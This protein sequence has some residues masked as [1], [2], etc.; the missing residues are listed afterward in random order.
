MPMPPTEHCVLNRRHDS[1]HFSHA[2]DDVCIRIAVYL[3]QLILDEP[4]SRIGR[5][6]C[7]CAEIIHISSGI[8]AEA[9]GIGIGYVDVIVIRTLAVSGLFLQSAYD[10]VVVAA[11]A[12][13]ISETIARKIFIIY[14]RTDNAYLAH[15]QNIGILQEASRSELEALDIG[16]LFRYS[17]HRSGTEGLAAYFYACH[18]G[19]HGADRCNTVAVVHGQLK[20][21]FFADSIGGSPA[22]DRHHKQVCAH[23]LEAFIYHSSKTI[24]EA[25]DDN[26]R[27]YADDYAQHGKS[28]PRLTGGKGLDRKDK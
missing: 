7:G 12:D 23:A 9:L 5:L 26:Y 21:L 16:K 4:L 14:I 20:H 2:D 17:R 28:R 3:L 22:H 18:A 25:D 11:Y 1:Q 6:G 24:A 19:N 13:N 8:A 10:C 27:G 15:L